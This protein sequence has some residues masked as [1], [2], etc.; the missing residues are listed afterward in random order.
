[1]ERKDAKE[2]GM[3]EHENGKGKR[4]EGRERERWKVYNGTANTPTYKLKFHI[5]MYCIVIITKIEDKYYTVIHNYG[6]P[7]F[8]LYSF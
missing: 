6:N 4:A 3:K 8:L 1:M 2:L 5:C 7:W